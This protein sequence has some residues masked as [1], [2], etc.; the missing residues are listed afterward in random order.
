M[1]H[2]F[3]VITVFWSAIGV[4]SFY[5]TGNCKLGCVLVR[6][7][8]LSVI[9]KKG[10]APDPFGDAANIEKKE[11]YDYLQKRYKEYGFPAPETDFEDDDVQVDAGEEDDDGDSDEEYDGEDD[12]DSEDSED[13]EDP[14]NLNIDPMD[15]LGEQEGNFKSGFVTITGN[16]NVGKS[17]LLN[18]LLKEKLSIVT[19]KPQT[20]R[21]SILGVLSDPEYQI[22]FTDTPGMLKG[23]SYKLQESMQDTVCLFLSHEYTIDFI[24]VLVVCRF[25]Q[26]LVMW[27]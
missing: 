8:R 3:L 17:S 21:H 18:S 1:V 27:T 5:L 12:D 11:R 2:F 7:S 19:S 4:S 15:R 22:V 23:P 14:L 9:S 26:L 20:T 24:I 16:P 6:T 10:F 13:S 25:D